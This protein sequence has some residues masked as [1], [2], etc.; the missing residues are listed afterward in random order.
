MVRSDMPASRI[1][2][3]KVKGERDA[4]MHTARPVHGMTSAFNTGPRPNRDTA[5]LPEARRTF[6]GWLAGADAL[7]LGHCTTSTC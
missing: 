1:A 2:T 5:L 7:G 4:N 6:D 3:A